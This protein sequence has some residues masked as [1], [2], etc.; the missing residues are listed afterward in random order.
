MNFYDYV[1]PNSGETLTTLLTH[2][3]IKIN[4]IVSSSEIEPVEY[5]QTDDEWVFVVQGEATLLIQEE[6]KVLK[7][8]DILFIPRQTP[9]SVIKTKQNTL[10]LTIH[11]T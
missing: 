11:I 3:N 10:W 7:S 8:G 6:T 2:K 9:H 1:C 4:R 5:K